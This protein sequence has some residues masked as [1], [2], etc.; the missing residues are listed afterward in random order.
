LTPDATEPTP[1]P[2]D[3][4]DS[5]LRRLI[6]VFVSPS[7]TFAAIAARPTWILPVAVTAGLGL[8]LSELILSRM[9]WRALAT[10]Q[11]ASRHLTEAQIEQALPTMRRVGWI[12]GDVVAVAAPF[13]VT[14][15]VALVLWGA[16]QAFGWEVRF[17]Q[18][19]GVTAHAFFPATLASLALLAV[20]WNRDT[21]DP[22]RV[23]DVLHTNPGFLFDPGT[24]KVLHG[25]A[26][27]LDLFSLWAMVLLVLGLSF[28]AKA[29]RA[30]MA[31]LVGS[32]WLLFV[33]GKA[34]FTALT[35]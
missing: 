11:M 23:R 25:L 28:A 6:G 16:C 30:R 31:V 20:L 4:R 35:G 32:L 13:V 19:L 10:K 8:P 14:L 5:A 27:S 33:L 22:E 9:D 15:L 29:S 7:R 34:G 17:P 1:P 2:A 21:I 26:A 18:S 24:D 3:G 12:I